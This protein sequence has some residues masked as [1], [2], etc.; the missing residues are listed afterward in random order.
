MRRSVFTE[1]Q[2]NLLDKTRMKLLKQQI[3]R[4][5]LFSQWK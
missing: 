3:T 4:S 1:Q 2:S 5:L